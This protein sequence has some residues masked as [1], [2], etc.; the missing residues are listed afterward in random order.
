MPMPIPNMRHFALFSSV[1]YQVEKKN[2]LREN[3]SCSRCAAN[4]FAFKDKHV[5]ELELV[6]WSAERSV[7]FLVIVCF[8]S[9]MTD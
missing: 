9:N 1:K 6:G 2:A 4:L 8:Y 5:S 7:L 3:L